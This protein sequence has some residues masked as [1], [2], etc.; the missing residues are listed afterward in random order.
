MGGG[1][2]TA[3]PLPAP[4]D[5]TMGHCRWGGGCGGERAWGPIALTPPP[6]LHHLQ[7]IKL[8]NESCRRL[9]P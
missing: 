6:S 4:W 5:P 2:L 7:L 8:L 1:G 3:T 9:C